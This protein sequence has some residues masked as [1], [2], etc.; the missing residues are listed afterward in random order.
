[1]VS[2]ARSATA[3]AEEELSVLL[4][5][6]VDG[7]IVMGRGLKTSGDSMARRDGGGRLSKGPL[8]VV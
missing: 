6:L 2:S 5:A 7:S 3:V 4:K 1:M 8:V